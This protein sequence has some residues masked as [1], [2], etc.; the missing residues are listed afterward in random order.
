M[1]AFLTSC[2]RSAPFQAKT[3]AIHNKHHTKCLFAPIPLRRRPIICYSLSRPRCYPIAPFDCSQLL[4]VGE[5]STWT[6]DFA[7]IPS[8]LTPDATPLPH[9]TRARLRGTDSATAR[10]FSTVLELA[11]QLFQRG[12]SYCAC[13]II[14]PGLARRVNRQSSSTLGPI[15]P[16]TRLLGC[17]HCL[18]WRTC[19]PLANT[20][21]RL[22]RNWTGAFLEHWHLNC[23]SL[24]SIICYAN[25]AI[26]L[27]HT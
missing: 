7:C 22:S 11:L 25:L 6:S 9:P 24:S 13:S 2:K 21:S 17:A 27:R 16:F 1:H 8:S 23:A 12:K 4:A 15:G 20:R 19:A 26:H 14:V 10:S 3:L 18:S 5:L